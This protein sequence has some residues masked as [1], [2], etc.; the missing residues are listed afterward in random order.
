DDV[1]VRITERPG[2]HGVDVILGHAH[3]EKALAVRRVHGS[4]HRQNLRSPVEQIIRRLGDQGLQ[5]HHGV[6][7]L[8][9]IALTSL[10]GEAKGGSRPLDRPATTHEVSIIESFEICLE[11]PN[12]PI[13]SV[14]GLLKTDSDLTK[15][16]RASKAEYS[17][18]AE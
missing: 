4:K 15:P 13:V 5:D 11:R 10:L 16:I 9:S 3:R 18:F 1:R 17:W 8:L 12:G 14:P 7:V 6:R 2:E